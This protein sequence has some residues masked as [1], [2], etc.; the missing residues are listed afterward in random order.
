VRRT[1]ASSHRDDGRR[2]DR[3]LLRL[4]LPALGA[5]AAEP[6]F[7]MA[8]SAIIGRLG[9]SELAGLSVA[10]AV[11]LN[12]VLLC[13]FLSYGTTA[14]VARRAGSGDLR[15]A[16]A[17]G[18]DGIWLGLGIGVTLGAVGLALAPVLVA[19]LGAS[20][21]ATPHALTYL[22]LSCLGLPSM[23]V[24]LAS[25]G[26]LR[27]LQDTRTPLIATGLAAAANVPLNLFLV[28]PAG[29]GVAGSAIGTVLAQTGAAASLTWVVVRRARSHGA[30]LRPDGAG[31]LTTA[32]AN[33]PI[34]ARTVLL[35]VV[36]LVMTFVAATMGDAP[37]A[38]HQIAFTMWYLLSIPPEAFAIAG[39]AMVGHVLGASDAEAARA[40]TRRAMAWGVGT[41]LVA[42]V[43]LV[44]ARPVYVPLFTEDPAVRDLVWSLAVVVAA[45][46]PIG[47]AVYVL[48]AILI[49]AGDGRFLAW[50]ML[51]AVLVFLPLAAVVLATDAGV[52]AL[53][54]AL[55][56]WLLARQVAMLLRYRSSAWLRLGPSAA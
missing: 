44:A 41:G 7:L 53:W 38:S 51:W 56:G 22:R 47:A 21:S 6:L 37:L 29:L 49:G 50:S 42:A 27:G 2:H 25:T 55:G 46:Q 28:Y 45:T 20:E 30:P 54:C 15:G 26:V 35:R 8:D 16:L 4:A 43:L 11:L 32:T 10:S 9:T 1:S 3:E 52:I 36:L 14:V 48:D 39:Q 13:I 18:I 40:V 34:L 5:L 24:V 31:I 23:L 17:S 33:V 12:A 19:A